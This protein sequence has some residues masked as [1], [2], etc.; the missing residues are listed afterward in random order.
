MIHIILKSTKLMVPHIHNPQLAGGGELEPVN[1]KA[2]GVSC[3]Q[4]SSFIAVG[5]QE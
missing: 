3:S 4:T 2:L 1:L 5:Q